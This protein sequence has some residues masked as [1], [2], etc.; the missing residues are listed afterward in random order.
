MDAETSPVPRHIAVIMDGNGR[1]AKARGLPRRAG[2]R[3][4]AETVREA[5]E[6]CQEFGVKYLTLYAFSAQNWN[7]PKTEVAALMLLLHQFLRTKLKDMMDKNVRFNAIGDLD[8]LPGN[9]RRELDAVIEKTARNT[10]ITLTLALSY[11]SREELTRATRI[12]AEQVAAGTL[13]PAAITPDLLASHLYTS[14]LPDPCLLIRTSGEL[15][16]SNFLLWQLS[17]SEFFVSEKCWPDFRRS[18][19]AEAIATFGNRERRFGLV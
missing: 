5:V 17:Y 15:R 8:Q 13:D 1:W 4:G 12:I 7:R 19:F 9:V 14:D 10:S 16:L 2:H 11:G 6:T 18:Q 3:A